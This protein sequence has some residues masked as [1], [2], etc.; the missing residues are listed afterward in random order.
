[1]LVPAEQ[2]AE[3]T[4]SGPQRNGEDPETE[5]DHVHRSAVIEIPTVACAGRKLHLTRRRHQVLLNATHDAMV[6]GNT[7]TVTK[8][9]CGGKRVTNRSG[10]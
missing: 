7:S 8:S 9:P 3:Q 2:I 4:L 6:L 10:I 5:I 1:M